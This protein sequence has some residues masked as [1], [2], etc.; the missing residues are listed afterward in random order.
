M[1]PSE[2]TD[3]WESDE[4]PPETDV[5]ELIQTPTL[6]PKRRKRTKNGTTPNRILSQ[7]HARRA[8]EMRKTGM[9]YEFI[10]QSLGLS[11]SGARAAVVRAMESVITEP[12]QE[13]R[14]VM[15][16]RLN[17]M[18]LALWPQV[19]AGERGAINEARQIMNDMLRLF[20]A[21]SP[22]KV[23]VEGAVS[24]EHSGAIAVVEV[25][26][27]DFIAEMQKMVFQQQMQE[28]AKSQHQL[29]PIEHTAD[30]PFGGGD[31]D[32]YDEVIEAEVIE[33]QPAKPKPSMAIKPKEE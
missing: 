23:Q 31:E 13:L 4:Y 12:A 1:P 25:N 18:L 22:Q 14:L 5:P 6:H 29:G 9:T 15:Y 19:H 32:E 30:I 26:E 28:Q 21:D 17:H 27:K 16:E 8:L 20:G 11:T 2:P 7:E 24:H 33:A 3:D 10:G